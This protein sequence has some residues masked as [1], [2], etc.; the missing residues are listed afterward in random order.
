MLTVSKPPTLSPPNL[1]LHVD[2][3]F[4]PVT[5][6]HTY[7]GYRIEEDSLVLSYNG[8]ILNAD[9]SIELPPNATLHL[10]TR[11][12]GG[13]KLYFYYSAMNAGKSTT[14]LQSAFNYQE[15]GMNVLL[16]CPVID[17]RYGVGKITSRIGLQSD[18]VT[19]DAN[20]DFYQHIKT[21]IESGEKYACFLIDEAQFLHSPQI[22]QLLHILHDFHIPIL[23]YGLRTDFQGNPFPGSALLLALA[24]ELVEIKTICHCGRKATMNLRVSQSGTVT[25]TGASVEIGNTYVSVCREHFV[26]GQVSK[27][28]PAMKAS[29]NGTRDEGFWF[30]ITENDLTK[31]KGK[32]K[33]KQEVPLNEEEVLNL[34]VGG[35]L[36]G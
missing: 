15:R 16:F 3:P 8:K 20:F 13:A 18:A 22:H 21:Q 25:T 1:Q 36:V 11:I 12:R 7:S 19:F 34:Q 9:L 5:P 28:G 32:E 35:G 31:G 24:D 33:L 4:V 14:L 17:D 29:A 23:C 6:D 10:S 27:D 2:L 26:M 30:D